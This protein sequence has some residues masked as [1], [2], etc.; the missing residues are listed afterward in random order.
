MQ[1]ESSSSFLLFFSPMLR[2][3]HID[4]FNRAGVSSIGTD[5][6]P[7]DYATAAALR[8]IQARAPV[9]KQ[10]HIQ[11]C[12]P[13]AL[14]P[15]PSF[16][17]LRSLT[18]IGTK[19]PRIFEMIA[20]A[21]PDLQ[22]LSVYM[23]TQMRDEDILRAKRLPVAR[24]RKLIDLCF[25][26]DPRMVPIVLNTIHAPSLEQLRL[27]MQLK[28]DICVRVCEIVA[29]R[30]AQSI[31]A[32]VLELN[33]DDDNMHSRDFHALFSPLY[34]MRDLEE[35]SLMTHCYT[36][37]VVTAE[38]ISR[39]AEA[40]PNLSLLTLPCTLDEDDDDEEENTPLRMP[41]TALETLARRFPKLE[42]IIMPLPD[43]APLADLDLATVPQG[44]NRLSLIRLLSGMWP[45]DV[46]EKG[47]RYVERLFPTAEFIF[48]E[49]FNAGLGGN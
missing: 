24:F 45:Q 14:E 28:D 42:E 12:H 23:V 41:V 6:L 15:V 9:I 18:V 4:F 43:P 25:G 20:N 7:E 16:V 5:P 34:A 2:I 33:D 47:R 1:D 35:V 11:A 46:R 10:L 13:C 39:I 31:F 30:F 44:S 36:D 32:F 8:L 21:L 48:D 17:H 3:F 38:D 27:K 19:D 49:D 29:A 22:D 26:A 37:I 40:W